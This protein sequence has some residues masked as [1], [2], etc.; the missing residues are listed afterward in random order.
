MIGK[1]KDIRYIMGDD[2]T[3]SSVEESDTED[4]DP[5]KEVSY[6]DLIKKME[7]SVNTHFDLNTILQ[8][9]RNKRRLT[10]VKR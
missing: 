6:S 2:D 8:V 5:D 3:Q 9:S 7:H 10:G 1:K 4:L